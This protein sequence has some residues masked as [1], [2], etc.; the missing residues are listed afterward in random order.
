MKSNVFLLF[1]IKIGLIGCLFFTT[2]QTEEKQG[3]SEV[4]R[5]VQKAIQFSGGLK[6]WQ[7][8]KKLSYRKEFELYDADGNTE[9]TFQQWHDYLWN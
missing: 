3:F 5:L 8:M 6:N 7:K 1:F 2:C 9:K 4:E